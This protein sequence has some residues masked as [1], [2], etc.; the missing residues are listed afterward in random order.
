MYTSI[1]F[2]DSALYMTDMGAPSKIKNILDKSAISFPKGFGLLLS[3]NVPCDS[4]F[5]VQLTQ[6]PGSGFFVLNMPSYG[7]KN[8]NTPGVLNLEC[9]RKNF[10]NG[11]MI[12]LF[13]SGGQDSAKVEYFENNATAPYFTKTIYW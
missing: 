10:Q 6:L 4:S 8:L 1:N 5:R 12:T 9:Q 11:F 3:A 13:G 7:W 2:P